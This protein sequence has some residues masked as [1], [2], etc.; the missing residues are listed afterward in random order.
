MHYCSWAHQL[1]RNLPSSAFPCQGRLSTF[2]VMRHL[3]EVCPFLGAANLEPLSMLLQPSLRFFQ[4]PL[5][6]ASS[7]GLATALPR[8]KALGLPC[9]AYLPEWVRLQLL[10]RGCNICGRYRL[11]T[12]T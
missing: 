6:T 11:S 4:H 9:S 5:P 12:Y 8:G 3:L 2:F 1:D 10:R 7:V